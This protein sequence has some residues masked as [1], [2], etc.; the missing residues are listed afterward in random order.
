VLD[1]QLVIACGDGAVALTLVQKAGGKPV[2]AAEFCNG[3][4]LTLGAILP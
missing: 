1:G 2:S 3:V 4:K